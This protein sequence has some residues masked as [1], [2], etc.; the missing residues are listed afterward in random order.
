VVA[1]DAANPLSG[2][3][4][5]LVTKTDASGTDANAVNGLRID[6]GSVIQARGAYPAAKD[7]PIT[8]GVAP[9]SSGHGGVSGDGALLSV[10]N[11]ANAVVTR[12]DTTPAATNAGSLTV[13]EGAPLTGGQSLTL[14]AS[15]TMKFDPTASFSGS[16][17]AVDSSAITFTDQAGEAAASL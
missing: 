12:L 5:I 6:A 13:G 15:G 10:S 8:I 17:I 7:V 14:D 2:P 3:E 9:D 16:T 1:N 11:G 4:V